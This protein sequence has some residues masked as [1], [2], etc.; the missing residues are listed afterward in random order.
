MVVELNSKKKIRENVLQNNDR[1]SLSSHDRGGD[2]GAIVLLNFRHVQP[3]DLGLVLQY[4]GPRGVDHVAVLF[5]VDLDLRQLL[6]E[7]FDGVLRGT[8]ISTFENDSIYD[9]EIT[10]QSSS[11]HP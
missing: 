5:D 11:P 2:G 1:S 6:F 7:R 8:A 3:L 4:V 10:P 9:W